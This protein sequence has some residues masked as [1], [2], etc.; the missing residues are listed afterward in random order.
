MAMARI[1]STLKTLR[2]AEAAAKKYIK[3]SHSL[4]NAAEEA[5]FAIG[6]HNSEHHSQRRS[7]RRI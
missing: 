4:A 7:H 2:K 6:M 1:C 3:K 5:G